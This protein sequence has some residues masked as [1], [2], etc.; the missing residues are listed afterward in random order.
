MAFVE[1]DREKLRENFNLLKRR[2]DEY[3]VEWGIVTKLLCGNKLFLQEV[4]NLGVKE[5]HDSRISN[6]G[7]SRN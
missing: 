4:L 2:F 1:L 6:L 3:D 7:L 5:I